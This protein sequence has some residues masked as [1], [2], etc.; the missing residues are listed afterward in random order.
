VG[1]SPRAG[2]LTDILHVFGNCLTSGEPAWRTRTSSTGSTTGT[3]SS[4]TS[5][6][7]RTA[8]PRS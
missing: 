5:S 8:D 3:R 4:T 6:P 7:R 1:Y 2:N